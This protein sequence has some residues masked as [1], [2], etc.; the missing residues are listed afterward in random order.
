MT[1]RNRVGVVLFAG[2]LVVSTRSEAQGD[3]ALNAEQSA[4]KTQFDESMKRVLAEYRTECRGDLQ[5]TTDF[6]N[7]DGKAW[8]EAMVEASLR[9]GATARERTEKRAEIKAEIERL[10]NRA[11]VGSDCLQVVDRLKSVC[12]SHNNDAPKAREPGGRPLKN[13]PERPADVPLGVKR[14][15][16]LFRGYV[17]KLDYEDGDLHTRKNM[18]FANEVLTVHPHPSLRNVSESVYEVVKPKAPKKDHRLNGEACT[19]RSQCASFACSK[20]VCKPCGPTVGCHS[21]ATCS[22]GICW[23]P[24]EASDD[25]NDAPSSSSSSSSSSGGGSSS[26]PK[27]AGKPSGSTCKFGSECAS[28]ICT[29]KYRCK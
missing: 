3:A 16:C 26:K 25:D 2:M 4:A 13:Q 28:K 22:G 6:E 21:S 19:E 15:A 29:A 23:A 10:P 8:L 7:Y 5:I 24:R 1:I 18:S 20:G 14:V 11:Y 9:S 17:P 27:P 12:L